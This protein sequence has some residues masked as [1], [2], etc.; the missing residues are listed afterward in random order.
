MSQRVQEEAAI[1][2][3]Y[4]AFHTAHT[5]IQ[6]VPFIATKCT[7]F[8]KYINISPFTPYMFRCLLHHLQGDHCVTCSKTIY[9]LL[10]CYK[11]FQIPLF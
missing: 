7:Q 3:S 6:S 2:I 1:V 10:C 4:E 8:V 5:C 11:I 9:F